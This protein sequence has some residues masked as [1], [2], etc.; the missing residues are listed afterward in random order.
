MY[1]HYHHHHHHHCGCRYIRYLTSCAD[2]TLH[3]LQY[4]EM[5]NM[6]LHY[7]HG[8]LKDME[9]PDAADDVEDVIGKRKGQHEGQEHPLTSDDPQDDPRDDPPH[10]RHC[11]YK[12]TLRVGQEEGH[13][14]PHVQGGGGGGGGGGGVSVNVSRRQQLSSR[15]DE[16]QEHSDGT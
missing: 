14:A 12:T 4:M 3:V 6:D 9:R 10:L 11:N 13:F 8:L 5:Q 2:P 7:L 1:I 16:G 15:L